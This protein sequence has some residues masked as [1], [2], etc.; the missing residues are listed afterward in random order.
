M[1]GYE[2]TFPKAAVHGPLC[3]GGLGF[4]HLYVE[5]NVYK[6]QSVICHINKGTKLG[7]TML[8]NLIWIQLHSGIATPILEHKQRIDY[9]KEHWFKEIHICVMK[10]NAKI[11]IEK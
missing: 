6:I 4:K 7:K 1:C 3:Y 2:I 8:I 9:I 10:N 11:E 5:S